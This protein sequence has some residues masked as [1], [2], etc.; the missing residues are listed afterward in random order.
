MYQI[1]WFAWIPILAII[2]WGIIQSIHAAKAP[3]K[4]SALRDQHL[5]RIN[6]LERRIEQLERH[7]ASTP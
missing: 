2:A 5:A 7:G 1:P 3:S 4:N 6:D